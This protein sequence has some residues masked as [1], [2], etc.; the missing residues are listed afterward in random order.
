MIEFALT[1][2]YS[3]PPRK[4]NQSSREGLAVT[5]LLMDKVSKSTDLLLECLST[6]A[7]EVLNEGTLSG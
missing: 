7:H 6:G 2:R 3:L 5:P 4:V 1:N